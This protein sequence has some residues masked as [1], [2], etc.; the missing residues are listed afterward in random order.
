MKKHIYP[1]L[2]VLVICIVGGTALWKTY[3]QP[4]VSVAEETAERTFTIPV[5]PT[6]PKAPAATGVPVPVKPTG[7]GSTA[8]PPPAGPQKI[9]A[10][11]VSTHNSAQSCWTS[12]SG[13]VYDL[14]AWINQ[15]P[16]G[17]SA[18]LRLCGVDGTAA[19]NGQHG[20]QGRPERELA[21]F[22]VGA[23]AS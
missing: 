15:H 19:F 3:S 16:G 14:T 7:S 5:V 22:K 6:M 9:T 21:T 2:L 17:K 13:N 11:Q 1:I 20:G 12:I 23:L 4:E 18:I 10:A 8:T